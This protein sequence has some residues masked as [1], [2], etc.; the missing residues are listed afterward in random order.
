MTT[1]ELI[2]ASQ[3]P[4]RHEILATAGLSHRVLTAQAD[5]KAVP[6]H[7][8]RPEEYVTAISRLKN[9]A[10]AAA[11]PDEC[12]GR[13]ILSA[14]TIVYAPETDEVLGKPKDKSDAVRMLTGLSGRTHKVIT[15]VTLRYPGGEA[16]SF[17]EVTEVT[18]RRLSAEEIEEYCA[19]DEPYDKAGAYGI[20]G[21]ACVFVEGIRGDYFNVVGLPVCR[22]YAELGR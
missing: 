16:R 20:Q 8:G 17:A 7:P 4:R 12:G 1:P 9:D 5:E 21:R 2:L 11:Y 3:S 22:V 13:V 15:G 14:D 18:F 19:T 10:V 6:F